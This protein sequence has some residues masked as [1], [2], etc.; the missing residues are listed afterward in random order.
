MDLL[1]MKWAW[2]CLEKSVFFSK[3]AHLTPKESKRSKTKLQKLSTKLKIYIAVRKW[4]NIISWHTNFERKINGT[5][6]LKALATCHVKI[7]LAQSIPFFPPSTFGLPTMLIDGWQR[8]QNSW[9]SP[10]LGTRTNCFLFDF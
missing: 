2:G 4:K 1:L 9:T 3:T 8:K 10:S 7:R 5:T 6:F